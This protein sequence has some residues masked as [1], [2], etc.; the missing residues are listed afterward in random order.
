[1]HRHNGEWRYGGGISHPPFKRGAT[2]AE[3]PFITGVEYVGKTLGCE[4]F[5]PNFPKLDR[6]VLPKNFLAQ[7]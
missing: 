1:M 3:V 4:G 7:R 2:G 6:N 5:L